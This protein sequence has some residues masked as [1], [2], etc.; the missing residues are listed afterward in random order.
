[1]ATDKLSDELLGLDDA[2]EQAA[3]LHGHANDVSTGCRV[4][5]DR[6]NSVRRAVHQP[7]P[8]PSASTPPETRPMYGVA[9]L[10]DA[11]G[12]VVRKPQPNAT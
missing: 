6:D 5:R 7:F 4:D 3:Q 11:S 2:H 10:T 12:N 1:M 8:T 9:S